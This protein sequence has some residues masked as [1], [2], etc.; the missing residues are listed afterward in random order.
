[1]GQ[2]KYAI[3]DIRRGYGRYLLFTLEIVISI[4]LITAAIMSMFQ[5]A[6][7]SKVYR[8]TLEG[9]PM[10]MLKN[11]TTAE[12]LERM[13]Q[14]PG[15]TDRM[16]GFYAYMTTEHKT[17]TAAPLDEDAV[18][19]S[20][21]SA[22][23]PVASNRGRAR[24]LMVSASFFK[25]Y[26]IGLSSGSLFAPEDYKTA[27]PGEIPAILGAAFR[28]RLA[29]GDT[30]QTLHATYRVVG[31][32]DPDAVYYRLEKS[33]DI[34]RLENTVL[35]PS[36]PALYA[37]DHDFLRLHLLIT[38][39]YIESKDPALMDAIVAQSQSLRLYDF[40]WQSFQDQ[41]DYIVG[42]FNLRLQLLVFLI[43]IIL[44]FL[45]TG[46]MAS[47]MLFIRRSLREFS[48]HMLC[49][50]RKSTIIW[51][52]AIPFGLIWLFGTLVSLWYFR[53]LAAGLLSSLI[54]AAVL[55]LIILISVKNLKKDNIEKM[56]R[57][58][59]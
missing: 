11:L 23:P 29:L 18:P 10:Y 56:L 32:L 42:R 51:R 28:D 5:A 47:I 53:A 30:F 22:L 58:V 34:Y 2:L 9:R 44:T 37:A 50:A 27:A 48:I 6:S 12:K 35:I 14:S 45:T 41:M 13:R 24:M 16:A 46:M 49:G 15:I 3:L 7:A 31:F 19:G 59:E 17:F 20:A 43:I 36:D 39:T 55:A 33:P 38:G 40:S 57:R 26:K 21:F 54:M 52:I 1:M 25:F 8:D 4:M